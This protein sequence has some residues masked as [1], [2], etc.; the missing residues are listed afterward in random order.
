MVRQYCSSGLIHLGRR[1]A[2]IAWIAV[3][4]LWSFSLATGFSVGVALLPIAVAVLIWTAMKSPHL[5]ESS[6][7]SADRFDGRTR[8][9]AASAVVVGWHIRV[10]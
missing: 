10:G 8:E 7:S 6:G 3:G 9:R 1:S 4:F 5:I 2:T